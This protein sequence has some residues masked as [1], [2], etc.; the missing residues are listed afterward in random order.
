MTI[1]ITILFQL[2]RKPLGIQNGALVVG[3]VCLAVALI[4]LMRLEETFHKDLD[5]FEEYL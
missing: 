4:S 2:L 5:Y 1:P 3:A